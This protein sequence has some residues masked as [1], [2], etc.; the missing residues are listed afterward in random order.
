MDSK[1]IKQEGN[2]QSI[3]SSIDKEDDFKQKISEFVNCAFE[4]V[5]DELDSKNDLNLP[6]L[7]LNINNNNNKE[8]KINPKMCSQ[9]VEF[10]ITPDFIESSNS[11]LNKDLSVQNLEKKLFSK[12]LNLRENFINYFKKVFFNNFFIFY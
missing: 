1:N 2:I 8:I 4:K 9:K 6:Y 10:C 7:N 3:I 12:I 5:E 11:E